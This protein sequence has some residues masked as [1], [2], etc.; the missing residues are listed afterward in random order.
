[1]NSN[2]MKV[3]T[4]DKSTKISFETLVSLP[5]NFCLAQCVQYKHEILICGGRTNVNCYSYDTHKDEYKRICYYPD[6]TVLR[7]HCVVKM[8]D[9]NNPN[10][11]T[12][13]S[14]G[15]SR[16]IIR[17]TLVMKYMSVWDENKNRKEIKQESEWNE[18]T[19]L[20]GS[21]KKP[22]TIGRKGDDF[23]GARAVI[24][25]RKKNLLFITYYPKNIDVFD[26]TTLEYV[27]HE[28][29]PINEEIDITVL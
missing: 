9:D 25:G 14:F 19:P 27:K 2:G 16:E 3:E 29:L 23:F 13:L 20:I 7:G 4:A 26:L 5:C 15:G 17:H 28:I 10:A 18:W 11:I 1:M 6:D 12:L 8:V 24:G 22:V 21:D